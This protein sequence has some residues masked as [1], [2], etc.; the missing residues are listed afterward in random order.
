MRKENIYEISK[1]LKRATGLT[2]KILSIEALKELASEALRRG[3][4]KIDYVVSKNTIVVV[5]AR[6][7]LKHNI[8]TSFWD[9]KE[10][11]SQLVNMCYKLGAKAV[12]YANLRAR[13]GGIDANYMIIVGA[14]TE[15]RNYLNKRG[16][17][18][19][20]SR[21]VLEIEYG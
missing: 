4:V 9:E 20:Y 15:I 14:N 7:A 21:G 17:R 5:E 10:E 1:Q 6:D 13:E 19:Q 16:Y 18:Y 2:N 12:L 11:A 3:I 8:W